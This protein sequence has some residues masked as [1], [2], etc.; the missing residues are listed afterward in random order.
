MERYAKN[1][2]NW[3]EHP[4]ESVYYVY[5]GTGGWTRDI[6]KC[7]F[8]KLG[9]ISED[10]TD[11]ANIWKNLIREMGGAA[12]GGEIVHWAHSIGGT[13]TL[14][15]QNLLTPEEQKMIKVIALGSPS[16]I[17]NKGFKNVI[18]HISYRD[19]VGTLLDPIGFL[20]AF[21][22]RPDHVDFKGSIFDGYP[23]VDHV[24]DVYMR[25]LE[26]V[27]ENNSD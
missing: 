24:F 4:G 5:R 9:Y 17:P 16:M 25:Y 6:I 10:A 27:L 3:H 12:Q 11:L 1:I 13:E 23:L 8:I 2:S 18:N 19:G 14:R 15:A 26:K 7:I 20:H 21:L 22:F